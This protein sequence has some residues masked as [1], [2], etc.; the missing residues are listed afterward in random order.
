MQNLYQVEKFEKLNESD[1][2]VIFDYCKSADPNKVEDELK[3]ETV[4]SLKSKVLKEQP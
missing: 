4:K 1:R 2:R 3:S